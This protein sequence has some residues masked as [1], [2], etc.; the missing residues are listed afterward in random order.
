MKVGRTLTAAAIAALTACSG[1][2]NANNAAAATNV[3]TNA[4]TNLNA[5]A[6]MNATGECDGHERDRHE[7]NH[8]QQRC[9]GR[10]R[11]HQSVD[12]QGHAPD[13]GACIGGRPFALWARSR[14]PVRTLGRA[15]TG[16]RGAARCREGRRTKRR[17]ALPALDAHLLG[18]HLE[19]V[20]PGNDADDRA[21]LWVDHRNPAN[22]RFPPSCRRLRRKASPE[23][24]NSSRHPTRHRQA[25]LR[26]VRQPA[27][28]AP[29]GARPARAAV[30]ACRPR[31]RIGDPLLQRRNARPPRVACYREASRDR[32]SSSA[33]PGETRARRPYIRGRYAVRDAQSFP[34]GSTASSPAR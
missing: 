21:I 30:A 16:P 1:N 32:G 29:L 19:Q 13:K 34:S 15:Q 27:T 6:T 20:L 24:H 7:R 22:T 8:Q 14:A 31:D 4:G 23:T 11:N 10:Q 9:D 26:H 33:P 2:N 17:L 18:T 5:G 12:R 28:R 25:V 3:A